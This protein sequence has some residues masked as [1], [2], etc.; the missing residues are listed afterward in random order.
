MEF[1][2]EAVIFTLNTDDET[3]NVGDAKID[4]D[5]ESG[6]WIEWADDIHILDVICDVDVASGHYLPEA[7]D[8]GGKRLEL[9]QCEQV[10]LFDYIKSS[11][12]DDQVHDFVLEYNE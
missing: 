5:K 10:K 11:Y 12:F 8:L 4:I 6:L 3:L 9:D 7:I 1:S 2:I